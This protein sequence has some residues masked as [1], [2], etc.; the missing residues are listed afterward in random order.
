MGIFGNNVQSSSQPIVNFDWPNRDIIWTT[1]DCLDSTQEE[2]KWDVCLWSENVWDVEISASPDEL[3]FYPSESFNTNYQVNAIQLPGESD[4]VIIDVQ[5]T[6]ENWFIDAGFAGNYQHTTTLIE[7][8]MNNFDLYIRAPTLEQANQ[9]QEFLLTISIQSSTKE[10]AIITKLIQVNLINNQDWNDDDND[11]IL[12]EYDHCQFGESNWQSS[13]L[14]DY[15][16]DG[17]RDSIEDL[18]DDNDGNY[19]DSDSCPTGV[20]GEILDQDNDGCDDISED[21]DL[22]GDGVLNS[23]DLCPNG[24]QYWAGLS[25]DNDG[26][27]CRDA[28]EDNNDDNDPYLDINDACPSG[29]SSWQDLYLDHDNDGC[30]DTFEDSD[31][32]NDGIN[33]RD[34]NCPQGLVL[35]IS[36][37]A[38]DQDEDGCHDSTEDDDRD[39]DGILDNLDQ[40]SMGLSGWIS[41]TMNDWDADGCN[42]SLEDTDDDNDGFLDVEDNCVRSDMSPNHGGSD[43]DLDDDGCLDASED[44]DTDNDGIENELDNCQDNPASDWVSTILE[45]VD[46][47]GCHDDYEDSDDDNDGVL[48][49]FDDCPNSIYSGLDIDND[50]CTDDIEDY[51]DDGDGI[52]DSRDSC[53]NGLVNWISNKKTDADRDGC[54]DSI[55]DNNIE[56]SITQLLTSS[57]VVSA[58]IFSIVIVLLSGLVLAQRNRNRNKIAPDYTDEIT[59]RER[60]SA[61]VEN[62]SEKRMSDLKKVGY[63]PEVARAIVQNENQFTEEY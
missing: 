61:W 50:G 8:Q 10:E 17:C 33:D 28:D 29:L 51:D 39:N 37:P 9:D 32:D 5:G 21:L 54:M 20:I 44:M 47:D 18:D 46:Q 11:G 59:E 3:S 19:D 35:W 56:M 12:D 4:I 41:T 52:S 42:D 7:N 14:T 58:G 23:D 13:L 40:C 45:D 27:G 62:D 63:S 30:H 53:P 60:K 2:E 48:D 25:E 55:E 15:D 22:D 31:D 16:G 49:S 38:T 6:P 34:D 57:S 24:A 36:S 1:D 43:S 26:D